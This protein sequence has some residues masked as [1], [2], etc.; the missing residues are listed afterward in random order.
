MDRQRSLFKLQ[1]DPGH[2]QLSIGRS[3]CP[4]CPPANGSQQPRSPRPQSFLLHYRSYSVLPLL[5]E[6]QQLR[7]TRQTTPI[8]HKLILQQ[9][10]R[11]RSALHIH[12]Q[13]HTQKLLQLPRQLVRVLKS[14]RAIRR[15]EEEC[16]EGLFV[17][18]GGFG[19]DHL[20][21][22]DSERPDVDFGTVFFLLDDF[23][24]HPVGGADH[25][26][27]FGFGFRELGAEAEVRCGIQ[28]VQTGEPKRF[29]K[30]TDLDIAHAVEQDVVALDVSVDDVLT[31]KMSQTLTGLEADC[32]DLIFGDDGIVV[33]D[34]GQRATLHELHH[35]PQFIVLLLQERVEEID[36]V[37]M[38]AI[39]HDDD[40][41]H[42]QL[43][44]RL[45]PKVHLLDSDL[46]LG[47]VSAVD[48]PC[49]PRSGTLLH[50]SHIDRARG[51]LSDF[52]LL[53]V[54]V[55]GVVLGHDLF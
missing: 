44:S 28:L 51:A 13:T 46:P 2:V 19:L 39:L 5:I 15:D 11:A 30:L 38:L 26:G 27:A 23:G 25:G 12:T 17:E 6:P 9:L 1:I 29:S 14:G 55:I 53:A 36:N 32:R 10:L 20:D 18:I 4:D 3:Q 21:G 43:L 24:R 41:V 40:L 45:V 47:S 34:V 7:Q 48:F 42:D 54:R 16:F 22:H 33:D 52:L 31:V 8:P 49:D 35:N 50:S 37:W